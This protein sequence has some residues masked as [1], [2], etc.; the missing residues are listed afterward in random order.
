MGFLIAFS[1]FLKLAEGHYCAVL[2]LVL[3]TGSTNR[4]LK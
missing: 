3:R 4:A 1:G 2:V